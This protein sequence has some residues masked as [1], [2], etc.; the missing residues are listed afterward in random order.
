MRQKAPLL[1]LYLNLPNL[2]DTAALKELLRLLKKSAEILAK[3]DSAYSD[4]VK[5]LYD[6]LTD[7]IDSQGGTEGWQEFIDLSRDLASLRESL[8]ELAVQER[9]EAELQSALNQIDK[10]IQ[11]VLDT[12]F[13]LLSDAINDWWSLLRGGEPTFFSEVRRRG[14]QTIDFKG[15]LSQHEDQ[16]DPKIRDVIAVFSDSQLHC[17]GLAIFL[18]R[19]QHCGTSFVVLDDPVLTSDEDYRVNFRGPVIARLSELGLQTIILTQQPQMRRDIATIHEHV[20]VDQFQIDIPSSTEGS[21]IVKTGDEFGAMLASAAA[22]THSDD[23]GIRRDGG[24]KLRIATERFCKLVLVKNRKE[25]GDA[26]A[27][28]SDYEGQMLGGLVPQVV[29][30]LTIDPS[31]GG[32]L[33]AICNDLNPPAHDDDYIPPRQALRDALGNLNKFRKDYSK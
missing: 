16:S 1:T 8:V 11:S 15:G 17:L 2:E 6:A 3:C 22:Y 18:A 27:A 9:A 4:T 7:V 14:R 21:V 25:G 32:K 24:K 5:P 12:K 30:Y 33:K 31:H 13:S 19:A 10:G 28:V 20:G 26:T 23:I 29:P